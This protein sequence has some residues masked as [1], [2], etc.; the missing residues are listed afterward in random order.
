MYKVIGNTQTRTFRVLW[1][2]E[3][4]GLAYDHVKAPPRDPAVVAVNPA[5]K[6]PVLVAAGVPITDS[7]AIMTFLA[8][9]HGSLTFPAGTVDRAHQDSLT[10]FVHEEFDQLLWMAARHSFILPEEHRVPAVKDSL[11]WEFEGSQKRLM[12]RMSET[13]P[14]LMGE[15]MTIADLLLAHCLRWAVAAKFPIIEDRLHDFG[16]MM[17]DRPAY[18]RA[19]GA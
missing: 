7:V 11:K 17:F 16:A 13:G 2:L 3:E 6:V 10:Q 14:F 12:H 9:K 8:D 4:L 18:G 5:G 15:T 19:T 1:A